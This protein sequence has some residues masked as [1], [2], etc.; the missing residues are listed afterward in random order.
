MRGYRRKQYL[1]QKGLQ[2][3]YAGI[4]LL[5]RLIVCLVAGW[6]TYATTWEIV[7]R[8]FSGETQAKLSA[9]SD[10][11]T[12]VLLYRSLIATAVISFLSIFISHKI[13]GPLYRLEEIAREISFGNLALHVRLR[14]KDGLKGLAEAIDIITLNLSH[15]IKRAQGVAG[16]LS[17]LI[18][19]LSRDARAGKI[20]LEESIPLISE[21]ETTVDQLM[22]ETSRFKIRR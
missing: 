5:G 22:R 2:L 6:T 20:P 10:R 18:R 7:S 12:I 11:I 1:I 8:E 17:E 19:K 15:L 9:I 14:K 16:R 13:A 3:K 21:L 4:I